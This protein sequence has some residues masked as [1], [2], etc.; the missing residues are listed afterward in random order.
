MPKAKT[1]AETLSLLQK[2]VY[3]ALS[4]TKRLA[5]EHM[6]QPKYSVDDHDV[7]VLVPLDEL[8]SSSLPKEV[9]KEMR[10]KYFLPISVKAREAAYPAF[11]EL[12]TEI[13]ESIDPSLRTNRQEQE[14]LE[15]EIRAALK[16]PLGHSVFSWLG[17]GSQTSTPLGHTSYSFP[18]NGDLDHPIMCLREIVRDV[19][20][21]EKTKTFHKFLLRGVIAKKR[22]GEE[23]GESYTKGNFS[24]GTTPYQSYMRLAGNSEY[25][26]AIE[27]T[28]ETDGRAVVLG[29]SLGLINFY[30]SLTH[31]VKT[32][33]Y[34]ILD[35][36]VAKASKLNAVFNKK[37]ELLSFVKGDFIDSTSTPDFQQ[38]RLVFLTTM[39]WDEGLVLA[40]HKKL[41]GT[42]SEGCVVVDYTKKLEAIDTFKLVGSIPV[43]CSWSESQYLFIFKV[44]KTSSATT[45]RTPERPNNEPAVKLSPASSDASWE[46]VDDS[47]KEEYE[48]SNEEKSEPFETPSTS[49][50]PAPLPLDSL[51]T[52]KRTSKAEEDKPKA[53]PSSPISPVAVGVVAA[54]IAIGASI[55]A[56]MWRK[57]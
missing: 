1:T 49:A 40:L 36:L 26:A 32:V 10:E 45:V 19:R 7:A 50:L 21:F 24:Y 15:S 35:P 47:V 37:P 28:M 2:E 4:L 52:P 23:E 9:V 29:S 46:K 16:I 55:W 25:M 6:L 17:G 53:A 44:V 34:E 30:M 14:A 12:D 20:A 18:L 33:G 27:S 39:C 13:M 42:L 57:K 38:A 22:D 48:Q 11:P 51:S 8:V 54:S 41:Q 31:S 56:K 43:Q 3:G 5:E